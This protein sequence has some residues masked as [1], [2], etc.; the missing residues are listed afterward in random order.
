MDGE[1][2]AWMDA[3]IINITVT[4]MQIERHIGWGGGHT[5]QD[6]WID[7]YKFIITYHIHVNNYTYIQGQAGRKHNITNKTANRHINMSREIGT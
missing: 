2:D 4:D 5:N 3:W 1:V 6:R 7:R